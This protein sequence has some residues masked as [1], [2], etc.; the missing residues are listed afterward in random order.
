MAYTINEIVDIYTP[1]GALLAKGHF[2]DHTETEITVLV[3]P[4]EFL[5]LHKQKDA[6]LVMLTSPSL[7]VLPHICTLESYSV[8]SDT[9][10]DTKQ[11]C[12]VQL[13]IE[14]KKE[15]I[16][17]RR[18]FK[19]KTSL[20]ADLLLQKP[21]KGFC[22]GVIEDISATGILFATKDTLEVGQ[23]FI[24]PFY[25]TRTAI[26]LYGK[27]VRIHSKGST[28]RYGCQFQDV[29]PAHEELM[30]QYVFMLEAKQH[31]ANKEE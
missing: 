22:N 31:R 18:D 24:L 30:R 2:V 5:S 8:S 6:L 7:G 1:A 9:E 13:H 14:E 17:R 25:R 23:E 12:Q 26:D 29:L 16:Q 4:K 20:P 11:T 10:A 27:I 28:N 21:Q 19:I 3:S 15:A